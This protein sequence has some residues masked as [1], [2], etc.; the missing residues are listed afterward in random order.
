MKSWEGTTYYQFQCLEKRVLLVFKN[1][2][3]ARL[4]ILVPKKRS[5]LTEEKSM[6]AA[7]V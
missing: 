5:L 7:Q 2:G 4:E 3:S 6:T 1:W